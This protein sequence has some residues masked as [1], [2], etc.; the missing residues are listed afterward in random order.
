MLDTPERAELPFIMIVQPLVLYKKPTGLVYKEVTFANVKSDSTDSFGG[1]REVSGQN[2]GVSIK[3]THVQIIL[4][5]LQGLQLIYTWLV[6][7]GQ[8][9]FEWLP[10]YKQ[11]VMNIGICVLVGK[12]PMNV[13]I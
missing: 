3:G 9:Y 4:M 5:S 13:L 2:I 8:L 12:T 1:A 11:W 10:A 7:F 6:Q